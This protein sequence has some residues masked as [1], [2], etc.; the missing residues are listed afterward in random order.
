MR[1]ATT[2]DKSSVIKILSESFEENKSVLSVVGNDKDKIPKLM[3][4]SFEKGRKEGEVWINDKRTATLIA[5]YP[6]RARFSLKGVIL[7]VKLL[8]SVIGPSRLFKILKREKTIKAKQ[9]KSD[10]I[11]LWYIGVLNTHQ[12]RGEGSKILKEFLE[13]KKRENIPIYLETSTVRNLSFYKK[14]GFELIEQI[15]IELPYTL[16]LFVKNSG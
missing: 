10:F 9:P 4:Y 12:N 16:Y 1:Q 5:L 11:H 2:R 7:D 14:L 3:A 6:H 8:F 15:R 13:L